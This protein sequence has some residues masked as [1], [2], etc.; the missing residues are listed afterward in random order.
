MHLGVRGGHNVANA[1]A[2]AGGRPGGGRG[3]RAW[4]PTGLGRA[5]LSPWRMDLRTAPGG[6]R[7]LNDAY[8]AG[9]ASMAAALRAL[10]ALGAEH[11]VAVLGPMAELGEDGPDAHLVMAALAADLGIRV[12][13]VAAP[14]YG[15]TVR[16]VAD[17]DDALAALAEAGPLGAGRSPCWSRAV[18]SPASSGWPLPSWRRPGSRR[19]AKRWSGASE[20]RR[21]QA[22]AIRRERGGRAGRRRG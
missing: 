13:A 14:D 4:W 22:V 15:P 19:P 16:H 20:P 6:A 11:P 17:L 18:A 2:A 5:E 21:A 8:N 1:L 10:A 12:V 7:V 3:P 9:P